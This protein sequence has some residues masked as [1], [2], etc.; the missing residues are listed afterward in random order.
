MIVSRVKSY[1]FKPLDT[2]IGIV[3]VL[4]A[5]GWALALV[6]FYVK[7]A[8]W[9][10]GFP[11]NTFLPAPATRFGD[12]YLM[13]DEWSRFGIGGV[14]YSYS[15]LPFVFFFVEILRNISTN[16]YE[17][18]V[19]SQLPYFLLIPPLIF[20]LYRKKGFLYSLVV[21]TIIL[22]SYPSLMSWH[23]GNIESWIALLLILGT[24]SLERNK[25]YLFIFFISLAGAMKIYPLI[26]LLTI[27][28]SNWKK[29]IKYVGFT[30]SIFFT[31]NILSLIFLP[32]GVAQNGLIQFKT[33][34]ST[35]R[36][37][38]KMYQD[39]MWFS[40]SGDAFGHSLLNSIH[41]I[42]GMD[43]FPT[44]EYF[45]LPGIIAL[46]LLF[47]MI[48]QNTKLKIDSWKNLY[49]AGTIGCLFVP[50]STDYKLF[51]IIPGILTLFANQ[52]LTKLDNLFI[53]ILS[54]TILFPKPYLY[55]NQSPF[56]SA[57]ATFTTLTMLMI[58]GYLIYSICLE[59]KLKFKS[60]Q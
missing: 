59:D 21:V 37:S 31:T 5:I 1:I 35:F 55:S 58:L 29:N 50:T 13:F 39:L 9:G 25:I 40:G 20:F 16:P 46:V 36:E 52:T 34:F 14:G 42:L 23:T 3:F 41:L 57:T 11:Y 30:I 6:L 54:I 56:G 18:I 17:T 28:N 51:Y 45:W 43:F 2:G 10:I 12:F 49:I 53:G 44:K 19:I 48:Y 38:Q 8:F 4:F 47:F 15:Y 32:N 22:F 33:F 24:V 7:S 60:K 27:V 26:F